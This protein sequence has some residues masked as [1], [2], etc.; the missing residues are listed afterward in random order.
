MPNTHKQYSTQYQTPPEI[1]AYM[2]TLIPDWVKT[3]LEPTPGMGNI[4]TAAVNK[5]YTVTAPQ[6]YFLLQNEKFDCI[7]MNPPFSA[8]FTNLQNAPAAAQKTGM[9]TGYFILNDCMQKSDVVIALMPWFTITDSD[10]RARYLKSWGL[11]SITHLPRKTFNY[12]RIQCVVLELVRG[13]KG[14]TKYILYEHL[15]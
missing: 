13:F 3:V 4:V 1:A 12:I 14:D 10:V 6:D 8:K 11:K 2:V 15:N 7:I 5:G 9:R